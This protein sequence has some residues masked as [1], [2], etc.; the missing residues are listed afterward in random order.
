MRRVSHGVEYLLL[1]LHYCS[2]SLL[3]FMTI[4]Q[5]VQLCFIMS[6]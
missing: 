1:V 6:T 2:Y 4:L 3:L 5:I